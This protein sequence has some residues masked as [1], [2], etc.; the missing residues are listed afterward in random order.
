[1][2]LN[3]ESELIFH[4]QTPNAI[5]QIRKLLSF[6]KIKTFFC[7]VLDMHQLL[8]QKTHFSTTL[9]FSS[10]KGSKITIKKHLM[11]VNLYFFAIY[12]SI[13]LRAKIYAW[14]RPNRSC[15]WHTRENLITR[16][17]IFNFRLWNFNRLISHRVHIE[18]FSKS[19][20]Q[21]KN[22]DSLKCASFDILTAWTW[23][24]SVNKLQRWKFSFNLVSLFTCCMFALS[25]LVVY[26]GV[27]KNEW[28]YNLPNH[29]EYYFLKFCS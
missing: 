10:C 27:T 6:I 8:K 11:T 21:K 15:N 4:Y 14:H 29:A 28:K 2:E 16:N 7:V 19:Q 23:K 3:C 17:S 25:H 5:N 13:S 22:W 12:F 1:M 26:W 24:H 18:N 9:Y 20:H